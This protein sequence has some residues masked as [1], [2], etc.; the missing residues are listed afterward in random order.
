MKGTTKGEL[1]V[2]P[3]FEETEVPESIRRLT[4]I[5][6]THRTHSTESVGAV[7]PDDSVSAARRVSD[8]ARVTEAMVVSTCNRVEVYLSTRTASSDDREAAL[9]AIDECLEL[10]SEARTYTGLEVVRHLARVAAGLESAIMGEDEIIGQV[11]DALSAAKE[12][13]VAAGVLGRIGDAALRIGRSCR[14]ETGIDEG[15]TDYG[16]AVCRVLEDSL[17]E[18]PRRM[19]VVGAGGMARTV[20]EAALTRWNVRI[21]VANRSPVHGLLSEGGRWWSLDTVGDAIEKSDAVVTATSADGTVLEP[22]DM[23]RPEGRI[24]VVDLSTPPDVSEGVREL[25]GVTV[26]DLDELASM[27]RSSSNRSVEVKR[28]E[29]V[30][31]D[32]V[33]RVAVCEKENRAED[34]LRSLHRKAERIQEKELEKAKRRLKEG[35]PDPEEVLEDFC[36]SVAADLLASPTK[37]LRAAARE[38]DETVIRAAN[39]LFGLEG[40]EDKEVYPY[41]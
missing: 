3:L 41:D 7:A 6:V 14:T 34:V 29:S 8:G 33:K 4:C 21:D 18:P 35:D 19:L 16:G 27:V 2:D 30:I 36:E 17:G 37:S 5:S 1:H 13:G 15:P 40:M 24:P 31:D 20:S 11:N 22:E 32:G 10:S 38:G 12:A 9:K 39:R 25:P 26:T 28:A 23:R